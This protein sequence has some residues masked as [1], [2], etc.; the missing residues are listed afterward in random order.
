MKMTSHSYHV[1]EGFTLWFSG[2]PCSGKTTVSKELAEIFRNHNLSYERLDGDV[3]RNNLCQ[4]LGF[5]REDRRTNLMR[6]GFVSKLL[7]RHG[8]ISMAANISPYAAD[9]E[10]LRSRIPNFNLVYVNCPLEVCEERDVKGM[11]EKARKGE[12]EDFT[13]ISDPFEEPENPE[14]E[15]HTHEEDPEDSAEKIIEY[16]KQQG[17]IQNSTQTENTDLETPQAETEKV[18]V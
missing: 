8:V 11:Y 6:V 2:L 16:L 9:R 7:E 17:Y 10:E 1:D 18:T 4:D 5:S 15:I 12:I 14:I 13:G 3:V